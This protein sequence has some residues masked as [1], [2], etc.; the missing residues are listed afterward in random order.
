MDGIQRCV[1]TRFD[2]ELDRT[3]GDSQVSSTCLS[4]GGPRARGRG[5]PRGHRVL[6]LRHRAAPVAAGS[7]GAVRA[8]A[9]RP[10]HRCQSVRMG[11]P[12]RTSTRRPDQDV[13]FAPSVE[14]AMWDL[15]G[16]I[17][18]PTALPAARRCATACARLC[19]RPRV[20]PD[21]RA[22][23]RVLHQRESRGLL[24]VQGQ[25]GPPRARVGT[26]D[27]SSSSRPPS[28][29]TALSWPTPTRRG[30]PRRRSGG[31][32][33]STTP[34]CSC[35]GSRTRASVTTSTGCDRSRRPC[36]RCS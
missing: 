6:P 34:A 18:G 14:Q 24:D 33:R 22:G 15:Q 3:I 4:H 23:H 30:H 26:S 31:S 17:V 29:T 13:V 2:V 28:D 10:G 36:R 32:T 1:L 25:G 12:G 11:P 9:R 5:R 16:Q 21:R 19:E 27:G 8:R 20:P 35:T 7:A